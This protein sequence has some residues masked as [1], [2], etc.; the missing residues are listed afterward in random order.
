[1]RRRPK[2][3]IIGGTG[4]IGRAVTRHF[5]NLGWFVVVNA[6]NMPVAPIWHDD[7]RYLLVDRKN[8]EEFK[9]AL[10][11]PVDLILDCICYHKHDVETLLKLSPLTGNISVVSSA[12]VY[13]DFQRRTL[14]EAST[15]GFPEFQLPITEAHTTVGP[16]GDTYS[17][18]KREME[19][20][21]MERSSVPISIL[22]PCAIYGP[23]SNHAREW[24]FVK[25]IL[26][27]RTKIP[28]AFRG[29]SRFHT[30]S[31]NLIAHVTCYL[32][33]H[34]KTGIFNV[35]DQTALSTGEIGQAIAKN[36][37]TS[38]ECVKVRQ[39]EPL[40]GLSPWSIPR[41]MILTSH[42]PAVAMINSKYNYADEVSSTIRFLI[43]N[44]DPENWKSSLPVLSNY[45]RDL[46]DYATED[47]F[48]NLM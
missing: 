16:S 5:L 34:S 47:R 18:R 45:P 7:L 27:G 3:L 46:F 33:E 13:C 36:M 25:R 40:I 42:D 11:D 43:D 29:E 41:P 12:S 44:I 10:G 19:Q 2:I 48:F 21:L 1:M 6:R 17:T 23:F 37:G 24:Y 35:A 8:T 30:T 32:F 22:R 26:D 39:G 15:N 9:Y 28:L 31:V 20:L 38:I 14:D 4:Q